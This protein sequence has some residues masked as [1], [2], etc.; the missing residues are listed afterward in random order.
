MTEKVKH[1]LVVEDNATMLG[2]VRFA[3]EAAG[4][5]V[6]TAIDGQQA[7]YLLG[8]SE[9]DLVLTDYS[10]PKMTGGELCERIRRDARLEHLPVILLTAKE[11]E[12]N[13]AHLL[14]DLSVGVIIS[15]PF[16]PRQ[17]TRIVSKYLGVEAASG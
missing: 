14:N 16:S 11:L 4:L 10:M 7:W 1:V 6:T 17:L 2:V 5:K 9:F 13:T 12:L 15:K 8:K 3:L